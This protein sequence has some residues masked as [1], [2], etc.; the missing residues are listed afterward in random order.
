MTAACWWTTVELRILREHYPAHGAAGC[1]P[2]LPGRTAAAIA[3]AANK[4]GLRKARSGG[5]VIRR[6]HALTPAQ[7]A[8]LAQ[9]AAGPALTRADVIAAAQRLDLPFHVVRHHLQRAGNPI[10]RV[11]HR[12]T[13]QQDALLH[14]MLGD[15]VPAICQALQAQHGVAR[16]IDAVLMRMSILGLSATHI[17]RGGLTVRE[18]CDGLGV[19][20]NTVAAGWVKRLGLPATRWHCPKRGM[21]QRSPR[22]TPLII[23]HRALGAFLR[24]HPRVLANVRR[25]ANRLFLADLLG[26]VGRRQALQLLTTSQSTVRE[27]FSA[28]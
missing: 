11:L 27:Q 18:I 4:I 7:R 17:D 5:G 6:P 20:R 19:K 13:A 14:R 8:G 22:G 25:T 26:E 16:S 15:P 10:R 1:A 2:L 21:R 24:A 9:L 23:S 3:S 28:S 12:W